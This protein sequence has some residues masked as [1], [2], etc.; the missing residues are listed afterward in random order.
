MI[1][2]DFVETKAFG[3]FDLS[4]HIRNGRRILPH[5]KV[6][7]APIQDRLRLTAAVNTQLEAIWGFYSRPGSPVDGIIEG[8]A[9]SAPLL[10]YTEKPAGGLPGPVRHRFWRIA[11]PDGNEE[12][13]AALK[14][15]PIYIADGHHR[16]RTM[17]T[18]RDSRRKETAGAAAP[19]ACRTAPGAVPEAPWEFIMMF[20]VNAASEALTVLPY[21]RIITRG[22]GFQ[23]GSFLARLERDFAVEAYPGVKDQFLTELIARGENSFG[24]VLPGAE[25]FVLLS[26]QNP[27]AYRH[28]R[29]ASGA[30]ASALLDVSILDHAILGRA[31][32]ITEEQLSQQENIAY[33][34]DADEAIRRVQS[35][36]GEI[37]FLMN[38]IDIRTIMDLSRR[39]ET[40]PRKST[41]F[42][43]KLLS[44]LVFCPMSPGAIG[45]MERGATVPP[46]TREA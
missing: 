46:Q 24:V 20:L 40:L 27:D 14:E 10:D 3:R 13:H 38:G 45:R 42:Y 8:T 39:G 22:A 17:L 25:R 18:F 36:S 1:V 7:E 29:K 4:G 30:D 21:H 2:L 31:L 35:G 41:Y 11:D 15:I 34:H 37:G 9:E 26:L 23:S 12:I 19:E 33:T 44:G 43:P 5:E 32:G 6:M 28:S 16:Y